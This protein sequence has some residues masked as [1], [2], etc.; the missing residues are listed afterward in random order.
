MP[1]KSQRILPLSHA[2]CY[3]NFYF[4]VLALPGLGGDI[5]CVINVRKS[6]LGEP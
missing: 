3:A 4:V 2:S 5:I 1:Y 6:R